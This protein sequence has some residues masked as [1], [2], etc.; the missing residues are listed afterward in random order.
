[1]ATMLGEENVPAPTMGSG[2]APS[3]NAPK[4]RNFEEAFV[5][6]AAGLVKGVGHLTNDGVPLNDVD[7]GGQIF[8][9]SHDAIMRLRTSAHAS[10]SDA[11]SVISGLNP[12][13]FSGPQTAGLGYQLR[14]DAQINKNFTAGNLGLTGTPYGLVPFDLLA[15]SRLIYPVN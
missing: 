13:F 2:A 9:K 1:M 12:E 7:H 3:L 8:T 14:K 4:G 11:D 10:I 6:K 5:G 15:P